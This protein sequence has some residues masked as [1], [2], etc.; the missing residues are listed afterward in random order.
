MCHH[1]PQCSWCLCLGSEETRKTRPVGWFDFLKCSLLSLCLLNSFPSITCVCCFLFRG[2]I[3][4]QCRPFYSANM[5]LLLCLS[6]SS[7]WPWY[8]EPGE[9]VGQSEFSSQ[10][11]SLENFSYLWGAVLGA[12]HKVRHARG[13]RGPRRCDRGRGWSRACDF[14]LIKKFIIHMK[15]E[16]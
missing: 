9:I 3:F 16:I 14:M 11:S 12:V 8:S 4:R 15:H 13:G 5:Q 6:M 1:A 10:P 7:W 2:Q